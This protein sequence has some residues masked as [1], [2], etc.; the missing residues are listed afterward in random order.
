MTG[1]KT[2]RAAFHLPEGLVNNDAAAHSLARD[3]ALTNQNDHCLPLQA[4]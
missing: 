2:F 4:K 1:N 3:D